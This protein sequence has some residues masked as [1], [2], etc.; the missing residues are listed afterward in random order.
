MRGGCQST[1]RVDDDEDD[2]VPRHWLNFMIIYCN[3][4]YINF[5]HGNF[6][7]S[8]KV[9]C[10]NLFWLTWTFLCSF[11]F[12]S[13]KVGDL[14]MELPGVVSA[15]K[16]IAPSSVHVSFR[17]MSFPDG[18]WRQ[19]C[20]F[21]SAKIWVMS[22]PGSNL[23]NNASAG[24]ILLQKKEL[25]MTPSATWDAAE[26]GTFGVVVFSGWM[27]IMSTQVKTSLISKSH[28]W[29]LDN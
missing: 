26:T 24:K 2:G 8:A 17:I 22:M 18:I 9:T 28:C 1:G 21:E 23:K 11:S 7:E 12:S 27:F 25:W 16:R 15:S 6:K 19:I 29:I 20:A 13:H 5:K 4:Q 3:S 14:K 10:L